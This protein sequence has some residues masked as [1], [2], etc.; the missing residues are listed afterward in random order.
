MVLVPLSKFLKKDSQGELVL[1]LDVVELQEDVDVAV[2]ASLKTQEGIL[3][4]L[5]VIEVYQV[6][7]RL[8]EEEPKL[9]ESLVDQTSLDLKNVLRLGSLQVLA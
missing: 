6:L 4:Q 8:I 1:F 3:D 7:I 2:E 5:L 9:L